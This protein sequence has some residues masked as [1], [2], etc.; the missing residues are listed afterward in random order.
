MCKLQQKDRVLFPRQFHRDVHGTLCA[1]VVTRTQAEIR[2]AQ[3]REGGCLPGACSARE[4]IERVDLSAKIGEASPPREHHRP[5]LG[6]GQV[7]R[8]GRHARQRGRRLIEVGLRLRQV[9]GVPLD[10]RQAAQLAGGIDGAAVGRGVLGSLSPC[11]DG[12]VAT[13]RQLQCLCSLLLQP[14]QQL[15]PTQAAGEPDRSLGM[16]GGLLT[17]LAVQRP[18]E[19]GDEYVERRSG[20]DLRAGSTDVVG[21]PTDIAWVELPQRRR[22]RRVRAGPSDRRQVAVGNLG[23][24]RVRHLIAHAGVAEILR[25]Q[26]GAP[27]PHEAAQQLRPIRAER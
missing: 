10:D 23:E 6:N 9:A 25:Q 13:P 24:K 16:I 7:L 8:P 19:R 2:T 15:F 11:R 18:L 12:C 3:V 14:R 22:D 4:P 17:G 20:I 5:G 1:A 27:Q 26:P 21:Q